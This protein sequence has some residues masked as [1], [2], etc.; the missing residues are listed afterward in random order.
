MI[1]LNLFEEPCCDNILRKKANVKMSRK[2]A[3]KK[4]LW[5]YV[6]LLDIIVQI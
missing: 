1:E 2:A 5:F 4:N 3:F 6:S